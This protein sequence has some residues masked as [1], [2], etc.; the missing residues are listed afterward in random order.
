MLVLIFPIYFECSYSVCVCVC[1]SRG[2]WWKDSEKCALTGKF[3]VSHLTLYVVEQQLPLYSRSRIIE[4]GAAD[5][6]MAILQMNIYIYIC[7]CVC[8]CVIIFSR[9]IH[10]ERCVSV[11][12]RSYDMKPEMDVEQVT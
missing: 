10:V 2:F 9:E 5:N 4:D 7:V 11:Y 1:F 6:K 3:L 12:D 8:V